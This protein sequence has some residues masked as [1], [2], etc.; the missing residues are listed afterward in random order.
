MAASPPRPLFEGDDRKTFD[1][2]RE[3]LNQWFRRHAW[4]NHVNGMTRVNVIGDPA[5][6]RIIGYVALSSSQIERAF[7]RKRQQRNNPDPVPV[8]LVGQLAVDKDYQGQ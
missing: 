4:T 2:G 3:S 1:C 8:T 7:L 5:S 6:G